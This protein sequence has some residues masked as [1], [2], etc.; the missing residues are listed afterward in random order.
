[1]N[2]HPDFRNN[3]WW[4][5]LGSKEVESAYNNQKTGTP[6][7]WRLYHAQK[8]VE[9][10]VLVHMRQEF[11]SKREG[12]IPG[13]WSDHWETYNNLQKQ[14][15]PLMWEKLNQYVLTGTGLE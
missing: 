2:Q 11:T 1:M 4:L 5:N 10:V 14:Y 12:E 13:L 7:A 9:M 6:Q 8:V 15:I 3:I